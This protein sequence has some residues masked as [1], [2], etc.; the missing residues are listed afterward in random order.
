MAIWRNR[1]EC[2]QSDCF[3]VRAHEIFYSASESLDVAE[4]ETEFGAL[5][6]SIGSAMD[7]DCWAGVNERFSVGESLANAEYA[8]RGIS[9]TPTSWKDVLQLPN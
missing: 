2:I 8:V 7:M 5:V 9:D 4:V 1:L 6:F 3:I